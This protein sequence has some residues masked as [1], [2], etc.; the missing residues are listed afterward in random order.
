M[1]KT[2]GILHGGFLVYAKGDQKI[3]EEGVALIDLFGNGASRIRKRDIPTT[4]NRD[5]SAVF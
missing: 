4:V 5:V 1:L 3:G 2:A